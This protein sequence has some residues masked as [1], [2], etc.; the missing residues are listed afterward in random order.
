MYVEYLKCEVIILLEKVFTC[1]CGK[2]FIDPQKFNSHKSHCRAHYI[3]KYGDA[4]VYEAQVAAKAKAVGESIH[5]KALANKASRESIWVSEQH[6]CERCGNVMAEKF[7]SGRFCSRACANARAHSI[8]TKDKIR[9][10]LIK[11]E[12]R[13]KK[14]NIQ[15]LEESKIK[16]IKLIDRCLVCDK[17][18]VFGHKYPYCQEHLVDYKK[19]SKLE[20]W[21]TT[22]E[23]GLSPDTT[24]RGIFR[25][26]I[27]EQQNHCCAICGMP[28]IWNNKPLVF[29]LDHINGDAAYSAREN[30]R[31]ICPNCDSQLD[32]YKAKNKNSARTKRRQYL[33]EIREFDK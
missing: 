13:T 19:Q 8:E 25:D 16:P 3:D 31:L 23:T 26:Y 27:M 33:Q 6:T 32:T 15:E 24:I 30:L 17:E 2:D 9:Q 10:A 12:N 14:C 20:H 4:S 22:G 29:I 11:S 5:T 7:G 28:N 18:L 1:V 21:L